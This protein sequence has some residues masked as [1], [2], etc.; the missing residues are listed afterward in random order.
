[1]RVGVLK[2]HFFLVRA[3]VK[4]W[5]ASPT[6]LNYIGSYFGHGGS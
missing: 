2:G 1:M 5:N 3:A 4:Y 6:Y